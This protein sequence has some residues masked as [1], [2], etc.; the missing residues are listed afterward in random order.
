MVFFYA[1]E[2]SS[3][4]PGVVGAEVDDARDG[5]WRRCFVVLLYLVTKPAHVG[6]MWMS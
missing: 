3:C 6:L 2:C 4:F 5:S 1:A